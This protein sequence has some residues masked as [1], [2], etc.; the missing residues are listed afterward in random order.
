MK[1]QFSLI[2]KLCL[3]VDQVLRALSNNVETTGKPYPAENMPDSALTDLSRKEAASLMRI[4]HAGEIC[5]QAL[6]HGQSLV[7]KNPKLA[8]Q[9]QHAAMEEGD[10]LAWCSQ[11]I[12]ELGSH[13]SYLNPFWYAGSFGIGI[14]AGLMGDAWSLGFVAE[15]EQQVVS[16]LQKHGAQLKTLDAKSYC[17]VQ[18]MEQD[19]NQHRQ[20]AILSGAK[21]LPDAVKKAMAMTS[22][23]MV[24]TT[25][26]I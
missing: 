5:A 25:Y 14:F 7:S 23:I 19:E 2:D 26:W 6:Y 24:K 17:I 11:R 21:I 1:K 3:H 9:L 8:Q 10:H 4:N 18:Q 16:H 20:D 13:T 15:T 12:E 22:K